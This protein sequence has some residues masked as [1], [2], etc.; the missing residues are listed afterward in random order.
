MIFDL[1]FFFLVYC[2]AKKAKSL[3]LSKWDG[4]P[5]ENSYFLDQYY[6]I[7]LKLSKPCILNIET[8][9]SSAMLSFL[10]QGFQNSLQFSLFVHRC[11]QT[12]ILTTYT[13]PRR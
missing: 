9:E 1:S 8:S 10:Y 5:V 11:L 3:C 4:V 7:N 12:Y 2:G 13:I 6:S